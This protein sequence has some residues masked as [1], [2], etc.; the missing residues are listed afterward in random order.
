MKNGFT[1]YSRPSSPDAIRALW[2]GEAIAAPA[3]QA[4]PA[5]PAGRFTMAARRRVAFGKKK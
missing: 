3:E 2:T 5:A 1:Q 4:A